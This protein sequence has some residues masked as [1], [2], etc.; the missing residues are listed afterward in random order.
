MKALIFNIQKFSLHDGPGIRTDVFFQGCNLRCKWCSNPES[1]DTH[2]SHCTDNAKEYTVDELMAELIKDKAFYDSSGGGV[3]LTGGEPLLQ[4]EFIGELCDALSIAGIGTAL[5][6]SA[7][8]PEPVFQHL[9]HKFDTIHIDLKHYSAKAHLSS[10]GAG[11]DLI[12]RNTKTALGSCV[13]TVLRI[14]VIPGFNNSPQD[15]ENFARLLNELEASEVHLLPFHQLGENKYKR[16]N[17]KYEYMGVPQLHDEDME[18]LAGILL[19]N[20]IATQIGG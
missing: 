10:T 17:M 15:M 4:P 2:P 9:L 19:A 20:G 16:L 8:I 7:N 13:H 1:F 12:L 14:P 6:T 11:N 18:P 5:E 3:T